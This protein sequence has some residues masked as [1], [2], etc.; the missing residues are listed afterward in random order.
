MVCSLTAVVKNNVTGGDITIKGAG[1]YNAGVYSYG[2]QSTNTVDAGA[3]G[4]VNISGTYGLETF[5]GKNVVNG[6]DITITGTSVGAAAMSASGGSNTVTSGTGGSVFVNGG[7]GMM[8]A[9]GGANTITGNAVSVAGKDYGLHAEDSGS[10]SVSGSTNT[11]QSASGPLSATIT[12]TAASAQKAI[13]MWAD[14]GRAV[15]YITGHSQSGGAGDSITLNGGIA[16]QTANGGRNIITTG[17]GNDHVTINGAIKGSGNQ[18]NVGGG[19]NT[20]TL[21]GAIE[22]GSLNVIATGGTYTLILQASSSES[23]AERYGLWLNNITSDSFIA[24][25]LTSIS[26]DGLDAA[27]LPADF[28][29]TFN[30]VLYSLHNG[31]VSIEPSGLF[32]HL[33]DPAT[34]AVPMMFAATDVAEHDSTDS[35][36]AA[37]EGGQDAHAAGL[38]TVQ[39]HDTQNT[40][41]TLTV[42]EAGSASVIGSDGTEPSNPDDNTGTQGANAA[43]IHPATEYD[44]T[45]AVDHPV[46][47]A[48]HDAL[49]SQDAL[50]GTEAHPQL[51]A[52]LPENADSGTP[53][54]DSGH[55]ISPVLDDMLSDTSFYGSENVG[56][57]FHGDSLNQLD[58]VSSSDVTTSHPGEV[59]ADI[60][61]SQ[62]DVSLDSLFG[63]MDT[64]SDEY[65]SMHQDGD[66]AAN[67]TGMSLT[68]MH[69]VVT[70]EAPAENANIAH[71]G[72][73]TDSSMIGDGANAP[74]WD[75]VQPSVENSLQETAD[76]AMRQMEAC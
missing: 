25:G 12:A 8:A 54:S 56:L 13:A 69:T 26:F 58:G 59:H 61:L 24:G 7:R 18:I 34:T 52:H 38:G 29:A 67:M 41:D 46:D 27:N 5:G 44:V 71:G 57:L 16:M 63:G 20:V 72:N 2:A 74:A 60:V 48:T 55:E 42:D 39:G 23:F 53:P 37:G 49:Q 51:D 47:G 1:A 65:G 11:V 66:G 31:G 33:H 35:I 75:S 50:L 9:N 45:G 64:S 62:G 43:D 6:G 36:H 70:V 32:D 10:L 3:T 40:A 22:N 30:D 15:N 19:S 28:L 73:G 17:A 76:T 4:K 14:G 21:N 68:D